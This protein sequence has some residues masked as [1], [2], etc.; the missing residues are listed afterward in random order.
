[1][2]LD[3]QQISGRAMCNSEH[4][5][6]ML[7]CRLGYIVMP[8]AVFGGITG[9]VWFRGSQ[10][11]HMQFQRPVSN[12]SRPD[13]YILANLPDDEFARLSRSL[14]RV[15]LPLGFHFFGPSDPAGSIYFPVAG[16]VSTTAV[17]QLGEI[18]EIGMTGSD[19]VVGVL[20]LLGQLE[21]VHSIVMQI[22]GEGLRMKASVAQDLFHSSGRFTELVYEHI[23]L[24]M[25]QMGQSALCNRLHDVKSRLARW[26]LTASDRN[27]SDQLGL[28]QEFLSQM[29]GSRRSTVTVMAGEL[30]REGLI[31]YSRGKILITN[32][33]ALENVTCECYGIVS[34][35]YKRVLQGEKDRVAAD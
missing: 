22:A 29:L 15:N 27:R 1:V 3:A 8:I 11:A 10:E 2:N 12:L 17:T 6:E 28:T 25:L 35:A 24:Q 19:G 34:S 23:S 9:H 30:Q 31:E 4:T 32:R 21:S 5:G 18:V 26:L 20:S 14:V 33:E 16:V 7:V 13:N